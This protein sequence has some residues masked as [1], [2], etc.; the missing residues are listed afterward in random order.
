MNMTVEQSQLSP[1]QQ[2][3]QTQRSH[4]LSHPAPSYQSRVEKLK[5][6]KQLL[7]Q[8]HLI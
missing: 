8:Y 2:L 1:L 5:Q 3:L 7:L 6:L 4:Y